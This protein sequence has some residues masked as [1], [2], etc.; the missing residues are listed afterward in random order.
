[1]AKKGEILEIQGI[2]YQ[3]PPEPPANQCINY[4]KPKQDQ[5][6]EPEEMPDTLD[7]L[8]LD[9]QKKF[10]EVE[11]N[12]LQNGCWFLNNGKKIYLTG[13]NYFYLS[14]FRM[15]NY[16]MP[17][18][19]WDDTLIFYFIDY[20]EKEPK[21]T[22]MQ[23]LKPRRIGAS[24]KASAYMLYTCILEMHV[25]AGLISKTNEDGR[26]VFQEMIVN[27]FNALPS[28]IKPRTSGN[29]R[30]AKELVMLK[31]AERM[32]KDKQ[33]A[34][35][36]FRGLNNRITFKS[37]QL[38]S[39]DGYRLRVLFIDE[40]GKITE[41]DVFEY[42]QIAR[43]ALRTGGRKNGIALLFSTAGE[44]IK[45]GGVSYKKIWDESNQYELGLETA[46]G[47][48]QYFVDASQLLTGYIDKYGYSVVDDPT[49]EQ[50]KWLETNPDCPD[51]TIGAR[52]YILRER[53]KKQTPESINAHKRQM[54]LTVS[55]AFLKPLGDCIFNPDHIE[56]QLARIKEHNIK[57]RRINYYRHSETKKVYWVEEPN[58]RWEMIWDFKDSAA[59]SNKFSF[60]KKGK[61]QPANCHQFA[62][63]LDQFSSTTTVSS[64]GSNAGGYVFRKLNLLDPENSEMPI[65]QYLFRPKLKSIMWEDF[66][67]AA[68]YYG[69]KI[70]IEQIGDFEWFSER[71]LENYMVSTPD[72]LLAAH[73]KKKLGIPMT[74]KNAIE[75][76]TTYTR[77]YMIHNWKKVWFK[78]LLEQMLEFSPDDRTKSDAVMG[79]GYSLIAASETTMQIAPKPKTQTVVKRYN[80]LA[81]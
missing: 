38:T 43:L 20:I 26:R 4:G 23:M 76:H 74:S 21:V 37:T 77:E 75:L 44:L 24:L 16:E 53:A 14:Y 9:E 70:G 72:A 27:A 58:G 42:W 63:G 41:M 80:L 60:D 46:S 10:F 56:E 49:P 45:G 2:Q 67:L 31:Q 79:F 11:W 19:R 40:G 65:C 62:I 3:L 28:F 22:G 30:A 5:R 71:H 55:E 64:K 29:D 12:R 33:V 36:G 68:E 61:K 50:R 48:L 81:S 66:A 51:P 73:G 34:A 18:F 52:S 78:E 1:M 69:C 35:S 47:L 32:T 39:F 6:W 54:P 15:D 17:E 7:H 8:S 13:C 25:S 59:E 57:P